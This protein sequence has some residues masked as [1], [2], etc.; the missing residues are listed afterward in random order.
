MLTLYE[1]FLLIHMKRVFVNVGYPFK[2]KVFDITNEKCQ[3]QIKYQL[4][5]KCQIL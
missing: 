4:Q 3:I 1:S 5:I 2:S